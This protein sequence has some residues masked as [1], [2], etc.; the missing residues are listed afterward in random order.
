MPPRDST[1]FEGVTLRDILSLRGILEGRQIAPDL[2]KRLCDRG[3]L[4]VS[5]QG[6]LLTLA[7]RCVVETPAAA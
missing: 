5:P 6:Y 7:G 4:D 3:W 1:Y 2:I